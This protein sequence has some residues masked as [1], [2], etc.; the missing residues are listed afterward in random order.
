MKSKF[1]PFIESFLHFEKGLYSFNTK[2]DKIHNIHSPHFQEQR[3]NI[4]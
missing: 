1:L 3:M 4:V 2:F